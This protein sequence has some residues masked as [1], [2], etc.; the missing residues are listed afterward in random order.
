M[1]TIEVLKGID[2]VLNFLARTGRG[3]VKEVATVF[4]GTAAV[5]S[6]LLG[7]GKDP[8]EIRAAIMDLVDNPP[9]KIDRRA[10]IK[11][12]EKTIEERK[13]NDPPKIPK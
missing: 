12:G 10:L 3:W 2:D 1:N 5:A 6:S 4:S 7:A 8:E 9:Q 13:R 11:E